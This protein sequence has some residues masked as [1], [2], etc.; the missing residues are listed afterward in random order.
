MNKT[1]FSLQL[2]STILLFGCS[3]PLDKHIL[4]PLELQELQSAMEEDSIFGSIYDIVSVARD[5]VL[6]KP[7]DQVI[8]ADLTYQ[9]LLDYRNL[10]MDSA[11]NAE[12]SSES[13]K[14]WK[15]EKY[16][17]ALQVDS[18]ARTWKSERTQ[19]QEANDPNN[20]ISITPVDIDTE[21]YS[22]NY[23]IDEVQIKFKFKPL[24]GP[25]DQCQF[26]YGVFPIAA[27][28]RSLMES[29]DDLSD[30]LGI[31]SLFSDD[32]LKARCIHSKSI[33]KTKYGW[34][35][36]PYTYEDIIGG[37]SI[38]SLQRGYDLIVDVQYVR[39]NGKTIDGDGFEMPEVIENYLR[40]RD[41][42]DSSKYET[43]L[44]EGF[45]P[46]YTDDIALELLDLVYEDQYVLFLDYR[47]S[48]LSQKFDLASDFYEMMLSHTS[49][50]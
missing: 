16:T 39:V 25:V 30:K 1:I 33:T 12:A 3:S 42:S 13:M 46:L 23:G 9:E 40:Y 32:L 34:Y 35:E 31:G 44:Q 37:E 38:K 6:T 49:T 2:I 41:F 5:S 43:S 27:E 29:S 19:W 8:W 4:T 15:A 48:L 18:I 47:D 11:F 17:I 20:F 24:R 7:S 21:Y 22:Y 10:S 45:A 28:V 14:R 50:Q 26:N 36:V